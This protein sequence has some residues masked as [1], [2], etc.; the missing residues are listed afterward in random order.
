MIFS[1]PA[2]GPVTPPPILEG[3]LR[4]GIV[5]LFWVVIRRRPRISCLM[6]WRGWLEMG[7][8]LSFGMIRGVGRLPFVLG[9]VGY[10]I[11]PSRWMS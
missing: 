3:G 7:S 10:I 5:F 9:F 11:S 1:Q 8:Q 4:G 6:G 2:M